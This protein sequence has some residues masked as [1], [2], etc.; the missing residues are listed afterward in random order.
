M[1]LGITLFFQVIYPL[2]RISVLVE[3][4]DDETTALKHKYCCMLVRI[5]LAVTRTSSY[6]CDIFLPTSLASRGVLVTGIKQDHTPLARSC[7]VVPRHHIWLFRG[8][9]PTGGL[10][11]QSVEISRIGSGQG[12]FKLTRNGVVPLRPTPSDPRDATQAV[13]SPPV[14]A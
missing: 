3:S 12:G 4:R 9:A 10:G 14:Y 11:R 2:V 5:C 6:R 1:Y 13:K 8:H 7:S